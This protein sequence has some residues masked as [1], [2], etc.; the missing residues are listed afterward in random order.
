M[1]YKA[2]KLEK[3]R[4]FDHKHC[5]YCPTKRF[6][7]QDSINKHY[8][9]KHYF[10]DVCKKLGKKKRNKQTGLIEFTVYR[11]I[12]ELRTHY[13]KKHY[14]C[15]K[16]LP[17]CV[18]LAFT[19]QASLAQHYLNV[20]REQ[21]PLQVDFRYSSSEEELDDAAQRKAFNRDNKGNKKNAANDDSYFARNPKPSEEEKQKYNK[22]EF[23]P[24][25]V[26][27]LRGMIQTIGAKKVD[28]K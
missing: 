18:D 17:V 6:Y 3:H 16:N 15:R 12:E 25:R 21:I 10:C 5:Q 24:L 26:E 11:D 20:H 4:N 27:P 1:L 2:G 13:R 19:D 22:E 7:D 23:E 28:K 8:R 14:T 9:Q